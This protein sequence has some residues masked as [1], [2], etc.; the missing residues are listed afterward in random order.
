[1]AALNMNYNGKLT[2]LK[3]ASGRMTTQWLDCYRQRRLSPPDD[4]SCE[5]PMEPQIWLHTLYIIYNLYHPFV[6]IRYPFVRPN[7][8]N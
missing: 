8:S 5:V 1:M 3:S 2:H 4:A 6:V 7:N